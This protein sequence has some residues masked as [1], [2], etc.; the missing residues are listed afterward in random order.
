MWDLED[1]DS[2]SPESLHND[3]FRPAQKVGFGGKIS[4]KGV[5]VEGSL[6]QNAWD[7]TSNDEHA[8]RYDGALTAEVCQAI[9][10]AWDGD[11]RNGSS[12]SYGQLRWSGGD[13]AMSVDVERRVLIT[14]SVTR[15][16][17]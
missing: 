12:S 4:R 1:Y 14:Q 6:R 3:D 9:M 15:I 7:D 2:P 5:Y 16:C 17:D 8:I 11:R 13:R 10:K